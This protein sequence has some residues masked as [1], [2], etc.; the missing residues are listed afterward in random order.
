MTDLG[1]LAVLEFCPKRERE[2]QL[3]ELREKPSYANTNMTT[4][5]TPAASMR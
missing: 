2:A 5:A 3:L 4:S 1:A